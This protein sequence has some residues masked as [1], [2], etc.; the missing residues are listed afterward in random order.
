MWRSPRSQD[1]VRAVPRGATLRAWPRL[2]RAPNPGGSISGQVSRSAT[3]VL[4]AAAV[5]LGAVLLFSVP[6]SVFASTAA[7]ASQTT[8]KQVTPAFPFGEPHP[9]AITAAAA[10]LIDTE[11][12]RVLYSRNAN[13]RL[14]MAS[15]TKIMTAVIVLESLKLDA[16]VQ[17]S[18]NATGTLGSG[19]ALQKGEVLTVEQL[20]YALLVSSANDAAIALAEA[21]AGSVG[22]F[23]ETMN[24]KAETLGLTNTHFVNPNGLN[25]EGHYSSARDLAT[26]AGYAMKDPVFRSIVRTGTYSLPWPGHDT[27]RKLESQNLLLGKYAWVTGI[28]TGSTPYARYC[29]VSSGTR[30]GVSLMNVLLGAEND[31]LRWSETEAL[32]SYGFSLYPRT[33]LIDKGEFVTE[34]GVPD[35]LGRS[36]RLVADRS[37]TVSL[38][39]SDKVSSIVTVDRD[40]VLPVRAGDVFGT[41]EFVLNGESIGAARLISAQAVD[42]PTIRMIVTHLHEMWPPELGLSEYLRTRPPV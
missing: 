32:M 20:L 30:D 23:V 24:D 31:D 15:I 21:T 41:I 9:Q 33:V 6:A 3:A 11:S 7:A 2:D 29:L 16:E 40:A 5:L 35:P 37:L 4:V 12:G 8:G 17:A 39:K 1:R 10:F 38:Y 42:V 26:L 34:L 18:S 27:P 19:I 22:S 28:K 13:L 25:A 14:P 36:I